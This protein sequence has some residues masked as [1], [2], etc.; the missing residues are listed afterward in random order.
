M[1]MYIL[2]FF[3]SRII[4]W[5]LYAFIS[6]GKLHFTVWD[7]CSSIDKPIATHSI[8]DKLHLSCSILHC[9]TSP[10][11]NPRWSISYTIFEKF[12]NKISTCGSNR[13]NQLLTVIFHRFYHFIVTPEIPPSFFTEEIHNSK[14]SHSYTALGRSL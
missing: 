10:F 12:D 6:L 2:I 1:Y 14:Q 4:F 3:F 9:Q 5:G 13:W 7:H 8:A 11:L